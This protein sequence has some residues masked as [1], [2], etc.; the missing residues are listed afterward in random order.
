M[1]RI[2][3]TLAGTALLAASCATAP[4]PRVITAP[5]TVTT[6]LPIVD[7]LEDARAR[8]ESRAATA[9]TTKADVEAAASI[10]LPAHPSIGKA[11]NLFSGRLKPSVQES[12]VR[13]AQY[14]TLI[15]RVLEEYQL[16][17]ALAYLPVIESAYLPTLTSRAGARGIWQFM[18]ETGREYGLRVDWWVDE[19]ADPERSTRAAAAFIKDLY[20]QFDDWP[21]T[22]AAY[23]AGAGRVKRAMSTTGSQ[24]FWEL[25][26][27]GAL[28]A[29]TRGYVPTFFATI[30]IAADPV[31]YGFQL[32]D[33]VALDARRVSVEGPV[34]LQYIAQSSNVDEAVLAHLNPSY[35]RGI[36]PPGMNAVYVPAVAATDVAARA[37]TLKNEDASIAVCT[38][39]LRPGDSLPRI[40]TAVGSDSETLLAMNSYRRAGPGDTIYLPVRARELGA[41][42]A[43]EHYYAVKKGDTIYSIAQR[44]DLSA[45][46]LR[47]LNQLRKAHK[48]R[49]GDRLRISAPR[50]LT[51]GGM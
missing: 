41:L 37:R 42:L 21:L 18:A 17:K 15:D 33:P 49:P 39:T 5:P 10:P 14:R 6:R 12:F 40:A 3:L 38:F 25:V 19:R 22:L 51:A 46:E 7:D 2:R 20:R 35:R 31:T 26:D 48:I 50:A 11:I 30:V 32:T 4:P 43:G 44:F 45:E 16:P 1:K 34:S 9:P 36:V 24:T 29:E 8:I 23:N 47:E 28:P 13:S 27:R